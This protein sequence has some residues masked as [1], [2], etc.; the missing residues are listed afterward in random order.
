MASEND[1]IKRVFAGIRKHVYDPKKKWNCAISDCNEPAIISHL[2]QR[3]GILNLIAENGYII[4]VQPT[5]S[6]K[7]SEKKNPVE[8]K[9]MGITYSISIPLFCQK[10]DKTCFKEIEDSP[11]DPYEY[12]HQI[13]LSLRTMYS[14]KRKK[15]QAAEVNK[16]IISSNL[17]SDAIKNE[18]KSINTWNLIGIRDISYYIEQLEL[19][20]NNPKGSFA[21]N[22]YE[23]EIMGICATS[24]FS[25]CDDEFSNREEEDILPM[26]ILHVF[27]WKGKT[28]II[29]GCHNY[30]TNSQVKTFMKSFEK[31][32]T[33]RLGYVLSQL[34]IQ[35]I[36]TWGMSPSLFE[37]IPEEKKDTFKALITQ[38]QL[39]LEQPNIYF[40]LFDGVL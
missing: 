21:F 34:F 28:F 6:N 40:N 32:D 8:F 7:W 19:E 24:S 27:P 10:H 22:V 5:D 36:E 16:R 15:E 29:V 25:L 39:T 30:H 20:Y 9:K 35:R 17:L 38:S 1:Q 2:L 23:F 37:K 4:L 14:E 12:K 31:L 33:R 26:G 3:N 18:F 11:V 13:L